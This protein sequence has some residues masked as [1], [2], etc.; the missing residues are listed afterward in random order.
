LN[1]LLSPAEAN[2]LI[3]R[4]DVLHIAGD[5]PVLRQ[6]HRGNWIGGTTPYLLT[7][8]GGVVE[9]EK[10]HVAQLPVAPGAAAIGFIDIGHI[11]AIITEAPRNGF[12]LAILP[13]MSDIHSI[14][15]LTAAN[16]PGIRD[17]PIMGW[18]SGV[19]VDD[20]KSRKAQVFNGRTGEAADD[21]MVVMQ[22]ALPPGKIASVKIVNLITAGDGDTFEFD[23]PSFSVRECKINGVVDDFYAYAIRKAL[24]LH[25]P[26]VTDMNGEQL[27]VSLKEIDATT[28]SVQFFAPVMKGRIYRLATVVENYLE[29]LIR[30]VAE[31]KLDPVLSFN[32]FHNYAFGGL[33]APANYPLSGP[34]VFGELAHVLINQTLVCLMIKDK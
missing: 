10:V 25:C 1:E 11:P 28:H 8:K 13:A 14:Y 34:V 33:I 18:I 4:G 32:C 6:L 29:A 21:R 7:R 12:T 5:E 27:A 22:A 24:T 2:A 30:T 16:I 20:R 15:S 26:L 23:A 3:D 31:Q 17:Y 9:R 19:H